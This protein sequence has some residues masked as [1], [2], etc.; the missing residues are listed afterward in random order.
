[1]TFDPKKMSADK[2]AARARL[3]KKPVSEKLRILDQLRVRDES[4]RAAR[5]TLRDPKRG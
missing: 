3:A 1:M 2:L 5:A 4:I